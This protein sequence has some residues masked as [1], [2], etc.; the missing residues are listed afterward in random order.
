MYEGMQGANGAGPDMSQF[1]G[2][3]DMGG[4]AGNTADDDIIDADFREV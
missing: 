4:D 3:A 2:G 1:T